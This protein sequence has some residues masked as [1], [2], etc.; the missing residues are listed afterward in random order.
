MLILTTVIAAVSS[1]LAMFFGWK[2]A[3]A[4]ILVRHKPGER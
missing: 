4:K 1:M 3:M 2:L